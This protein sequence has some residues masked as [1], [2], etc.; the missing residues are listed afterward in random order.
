MVTTIQLSENVK[1]DLDRFKQGKKAY[2]DV[3]IELISHIDN[4]QKEREK[5]LKEEAIALSEESLK[6]SKEWEGA[7]MDGLDKDEKWEY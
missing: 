5:L 7:L 1:K 6:I 2:E 3:I 4:S